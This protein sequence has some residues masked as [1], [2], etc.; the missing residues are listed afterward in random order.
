LS[1]S[2]KQIHI[3][4]YVFTDWDEIDNEDIA[5]LK[6]K[7]PKHVTREGNMDFSVLNEQFDGGFI[8][9]TQ[10]ETAHGAKS[11]RNIKIDDI[12]ANNSVVL[13]IAKI[14]PPHKCVTTY[15]NGKP[16]MTGNNNNV[17]YSSCGKQSTTRDSHTNPATKDSDVLYHILT[18][19]GDF[20]IKKVRIAHYNSC[21]ETLLAN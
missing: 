6:H 14:K 10:I 11:I 17:F 16:H 13:G 19:T 18:S 9:S 20:F 3:G 15:I 8:E 5:T 7:M 2:T 1:T 12:L 21:F 4:N